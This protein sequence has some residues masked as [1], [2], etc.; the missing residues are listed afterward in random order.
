[1]ASSRLARRGPKDR[2]SVVG[3]SIGAASVPSQ[4]SRKAW[5]KVCGW[6]AQPKGGMGLLSEFITVFLNKVNGSDD[7][8]TNVDGIDVVVAA[9]MA[10]SDVRHK[11]HTPKPQEQNKR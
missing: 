9:A 11:K 2:S 5:S 1:M 7:V 4:Y 6:C 8:S 10:V 3:Q